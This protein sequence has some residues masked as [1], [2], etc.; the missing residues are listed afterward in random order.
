[1]MSTATGDDVVREARTWVGV[2]WRHQGRSDRGVDCVGV[3][4][5][6]ARSLGI[7]DYDMTNYPRRPDGSFIS[8]FREHLDPV[9]PDEARDGDVLVFAE[10]RHP[11][12][13]GI[14]TTRHGR[15]AVV[16]AHAGRRAVLE[17][18]LEAA[19]SIVGKPVYHF[20]FRGLGD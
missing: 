3:P 13:C 10:G 6:V 14:R 4:V 19:L 17:E 15:P 11:C 18:T 2:P 1:M 16:H 5:L 12:H 9:R 20:R 7:S 8:Y